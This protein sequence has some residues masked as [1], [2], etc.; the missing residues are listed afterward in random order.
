[1]GD[2]GTHTSAKKLAVTKA[3]QIVR[4]EKGAKSKYCTKQCSIWLISYWTLM[5]VWVSFG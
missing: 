5:G 4:N 3:P 2:V 1:M